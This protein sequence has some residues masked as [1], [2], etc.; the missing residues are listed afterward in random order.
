MQEKVFEALLLFLRISP[1]KVVSP[2]LSYEPFSQLRAYILEVHKKSDQR[3]G[4]WCLRTTLAYI[5]L[6]YEVLKCITDFLNV[7]C[8][9]YFILKFQ[10][11][12]KYLYMV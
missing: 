12:S 6:L 1:G 3:K 2:D 8:L 9:S 10:S 5:H 4:Y 7:L 11:G